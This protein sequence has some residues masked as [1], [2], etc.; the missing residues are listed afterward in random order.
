[1]TAYRAIAGAD[2]RPKMT[3]ILKPGGKPIEVSRVED[4]GLVSDHW[5][6]LYDADGK[7]ADE[8]ATYK[9]HWYAEVVS[10]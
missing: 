8:G 4:A 9:K 5:I 10:P 7:L 3:I 2:I 1:M 6:Y